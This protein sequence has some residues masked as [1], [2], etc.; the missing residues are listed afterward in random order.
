MNQPYQQH[1]AKPVLKIKPVQYGNLS[2][3]ENFYISEGIV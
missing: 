1:T 2:V 3:A